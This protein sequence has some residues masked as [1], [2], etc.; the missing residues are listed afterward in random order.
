MSSIT[1]EIL[2]NDEIIVL[3]QSLIKDYKTE[4]VQ[5]AIKALAQKYKGDFNLAIIPYFKDVELYIVY[6]ITEPMKLDL[7]MKMINEFQDTLMA[8][9]Y[10]EKLEKIFG[11]YPS[12]EL[13]NQVSEMNGLG[14]NPLLRHMEYRYKLIAPIAPVPSYVGEYGVNINKVSKIKEYIRD[15]DHSS[16]LPSILAMRSDIILTNEDGEIGMEEREEI[17]KHMI[18]EMTE[19]D[20]SEFRTSMKINQQEIIDVRMD[21]DV[22]R[23]HG[24]VCSYQSVDFGKLRDEYGKLD[25]DKIYGGARMFTEKDWFKGN[26]D[27]CLQRISAYHHAV[28]KPELKGGWNGCYCSFDC[29]RKTVE[30]DDTVMLGLIALVEKDVITNGIQDR[31]YKKPDD[32]YTYDYEAIVAIVYGSTAC[33]PLQA[34][35]QD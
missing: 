31:E 10:Y 7:I 29:V 14:L 11:F 6:K 32:P 24:P 27:I 13:M 22:F 5:Q 4:E 3:V 26:C 1:D 12:K 19:E 28:R 18:E 25:A 33:Q 16:V 20:L 21:I 9:V 35:I 17:F 15:E 23:A 34:M 30:E 2:T 8:V